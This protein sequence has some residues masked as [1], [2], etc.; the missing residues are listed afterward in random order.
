MAR[1]FGHFRT[2]TSCGLHEGFIYT[3]GIHG[4]VRADP[5]NWQIGQIAVE[6]TT[7]LSP[8]KNCWPKILFWNEKA[9]KNLQNKT[10]FTWFN[11]DMVEIFPGEVSRFRAFAVVMAT[12]NLDSSE[13]FLNSKSRAKKSL[14]KAK[15]MW[16]VVHTVFIFEWSRHF[17][18]SDSVAGYT[19]SKPGF[20]CNIVWI[21]GWITEF[22]WA[23]IRTMK[24]SEKQGQFCLFLKWS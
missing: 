23:E 8:Y 22:V 7:Y 21:T 13:R 24:N 2:E 3:A 11:R 15:I 4:K 19:L 20:E 10:N 6:N 18:K 16:S 9:K 14:G 17:R 5:T 1:N 12:S